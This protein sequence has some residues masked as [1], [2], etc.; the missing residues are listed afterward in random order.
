MSRWLQRVA[1]A[2]LLGVVFFAALTARVIAEGERELAQS[3]RAFDRGDLREAVLHA[4]RSATS[5]AP[6]A[7]HVAAAYDRLSAIARGAEA[8]GQVDLARQA[9][10]AMRGAALESRHLFSPHEAELARADADLVRL[11]SRSGPGPA[12]DL[13]RLPAQLARDEAPRGPWVLVLSLGFAVFGLGLGLFATRG[14]GPTGALSRRWTF[15]SLGLC[16]LGA[17]C[18]TLSV[19]RA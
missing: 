19:Y 3:D 16:L 12:P 14:L 6:G 7:P 11:A 17:A 4:R 18:W 13:S 2:L 5:Y 8:S 10:T 15:V 9:L 1:L